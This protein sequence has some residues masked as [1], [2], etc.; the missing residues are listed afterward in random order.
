M[1]L[2][3]VGTF[4][5]LDVNVPTDSERIFDG[6]NYAKDLSLYLYSPEFAFQRSGL[7]LRLSSRQ[8]YLSKNERFDLKNL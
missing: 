8:R 6:K 7:W 5:L 1:S 3:G 2:E 4:T